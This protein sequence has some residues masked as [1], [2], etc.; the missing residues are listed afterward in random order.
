MQD[1]AAVVH[2]PWDRLRRY[3][4]NTRSSSKSKSDQAIEE[5]KQKLSTSFVESKTKILL[6]MATAIVIIIVISQSTVAVPAGHRGVVLYLGAVEDRVLSEGFSFILP[7]VEHAVL[8]EVRT[9]KYQAPATASSQDLQLVSTEVALNYHLD[10]TIV[11]DIYQT[12]GE[13]YADR[14]MAPTIQE[15]VKASTAKFAAEELI[16]KREEAKATIG[17]V[18]RTTLVSRGIITEQVFITDFQFSDDFVKA[19]ESKV[20]AAQEVLRERNFLEKVRIQAQSREAQAIGIGNAKIAEAKGE[21]EAIKI[22]NEQLKQNPDY[23]RWQAIENWN[24]EL[25][26]ATGGTFPFIDISL[27]SQN[28]HNS[29]SEN[30]DKETNRLD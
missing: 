27:L 14:I 18:I 12:L 1:D 11:N 16:T 4:K 2:S 20:V 15:S 10:P 30:S 3:F 29:T 5:Y 22:I 8:M 23:L 26:M 19:V 9:Q 17:E 7:F 25:P 21:S 24:G 28:R 6:G 13:N